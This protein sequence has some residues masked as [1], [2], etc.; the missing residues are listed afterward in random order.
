MSFTTEAKR[1]KAGQSLTDMFNQA[2]GAISQ[3]NAI[4][5]NLLNL[6][7][8]MVDDTDYTTED[9]AEV[10]AKISELAIAIQAIIS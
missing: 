6:K 3:L 2:Q 7:T 9:T 10:D 1:V 8:S 4:K 5:T